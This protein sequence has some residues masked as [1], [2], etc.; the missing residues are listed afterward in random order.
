MFDWLVGGTVEPKDIALLWLCFGTLVALL[1][2][3]L[4]QGYLAR[5][6]IEELEERVRSLE[7]HLRAAEDRERDALRRSIGK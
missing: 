6:R 4:W 5:Q 3:S 2:F 1:V 7:F